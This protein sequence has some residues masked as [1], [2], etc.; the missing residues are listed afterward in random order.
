MTFGNILFPVDFSERCRAVAP[1]VDAVVTRHKASL[2]LLHL[3]EIPTI[4]N[5]SAEAPFMPDVNAP[6]L[7]DDAAKR[8]ECFAMENLCGLKPELI[9]DTGDPGSCIVEIAK[10][11]GADLIMMPTR[12]RGRFRS[13]LLGSVT[14]KV[15]HDA[16]CA[17]W[18]AAHLDESLATMSPDWRTVVCGI[19]TSPDAVRL[20]RFAADLQSSSGASIEMVHALPASPETGPKMYMGREFQAFLEQSASQSIERMQTAAG[21]IF[22]VCMEAGKVAEVIASAARDLY[23]D[24][25]LIGRGALPH[26]AGRLTSNVYAIIRDARCPVLS[27]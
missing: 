19:D 2:T 14:A 27:V 15:L 25:V 11:S 23:A 22:P 20:I 21:V 5:G 16:E 9:V 17:V 7:L 26:V 24:L 10:T 3:V 6:Q 18:T 1:F 4:W 13:A 12:G 8:L